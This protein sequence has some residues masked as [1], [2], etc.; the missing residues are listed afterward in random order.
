[1]AG[2]N[3]P[4]RFFAHASHVSISLSPVSCLTHPCCSLTVT[5][6]PF[7][8]LTSTRSCRAYLSCKRKACASPHEQREVWLSGQVRSQHRFW[9]QEVRQDHFCGQWHDAHWRSRPQ[10]NLWLLEKHRS[11]ESMHRE[12]DCWTDRERGGSV[13]SVAESMSKK[14]RRNNLGSHSLRTH[15]EFY[16]D[17]RVLQEHLEQELNKLFL[18]KIRIREDETWLSTTW[19][20]R[21]WNEEIQNTHYSNHSVSLN[22]KD[23]NYGKPIHMQIKLDVREYVCVAN[24]RW[25][26]IFYQESYA[27]SCREIEESKKMLLSGRKYWK[28]TKIGRISYAA[29]AGITNSEV[30]LSFYDPDLR[31]SYKR[32]TFLIKIL[33]L[34]VQESQAAKLDASKYWR[35]EY[36]WKRFWCHRGL[37]CQLSS[38]L[39]TYT[40]RLLSARVRHNNNY[41]IWCGYFVTGEELPPH[42]GGLKHALLQAGGPTQFPAFPPYVVKT[43]HLHGAPTTKET[44]FVKP[45]FK[46]WKRKNKQRKRK[47][48]EQEQ[49]KKNKKQGEKKE[50]TKGGKTKKRG[51]KGVYS[52]RRA[53]KVTY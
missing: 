1:M 50:K 51:L 35:Y 37:P 15:K 4:T 52:P 12:T 17:E 29:W 25:R 5:S 24:R 10:W 8:T 22:L 26:T 20:S 44:S 9:A 53:E 46:C 7:L 47:K 43:P 11:K 18:V 38:E 42:S 3:V 34:R 39:R 48:Q 40:C 14:S 23:D 2:S 19:R 36:S 41:T 49:K 6:R 31:S 27:R 30:S 21:I 28:T 13:I 33:L 16:S 32:H 45:W